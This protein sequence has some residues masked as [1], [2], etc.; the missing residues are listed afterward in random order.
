MPQ[1]CKVIVII[2]SHLIA[3]VDPLHSPHGCLDELSGMDNEHD[4][5]DKPHEESVED[6]DESLMLGYNTATARR[7]L[8][9][10]DQRSHEDSHAGGVNSVHV[11]FPVHRTQDFGRLTVQ[12]HVHA[13]GD[14]DEEAEGEELEDEAAQ[15]GFVAGGHGLGVSGCL[16][17]GTADLGEKD[18]DVDEDVDFG[19]PGDAD[20]RV[21]PCVQNAD[22]ATERHVYGGAKP[23]G[24][25]E[26]KQ[27]LEDE[28]LDFV[29]VF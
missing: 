12:T 7:I 27:N 11:F 14:E 17:A 4:H 6:V 13:P 18:D 21:F 26:D 23:G 2:A 9:S 20:H 22:D 1:G 29:H 3:R 8:D 10:A 28:G 24:S 16:D 5:H 15:D 25:G 19:Q